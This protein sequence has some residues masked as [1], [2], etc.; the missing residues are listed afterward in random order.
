MGMRFSVAVLAALVSI[1]L[2]ALSSRA[3]EAADAAHIRPW[4]LTSSE[5]WIP[6]DPSELAIAALTPVRVS[7]QRM[8]AS[9]QRVEHMALT[10][11]GA[12][13]LEAA[14][15]P[16]HLPSIYDAA[17]VEEEAHCLALGLY[18]EARGE[19]ELG[20][21]AVAQ[22]ILNRVKS[23][24]YPGSICGVVFENEHRFNACQF[25]FACDGR[26]D[27]PENWP[28]YQKMKQ[29]ADE[30]LCNP[31]CSYHVH[32]DPPLARLP[33]SMRRAS[34]Y[35]TFRVNPGWSRRINRVGQIGAHIFYIS[36]RVMSSL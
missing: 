31:E 24:K 15:L 17:N 12:D 29:L 26:S 34:H 27:K 8:V 23:P 33:S 7:P 16:L 30:V 11:P 28:M 4:H 35:H 10:L 9:R 2:S 14:P 22:V 19:T 6:A 18:H 21:I 5:T 36:E 13:I 1:L 32:R 20:Q 3:V 25:S